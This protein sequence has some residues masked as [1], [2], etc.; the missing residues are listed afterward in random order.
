M[1]ITV[2]FDYHSSIENARV[3]RIDIGI[4]DMYDVSVAWLSSYIYQEKIELSKRKISF[5]IPKIQLNEG[6][7]N[8]NLYSTVDNEVSDWVKNVS[9]INIVFGNYY[10]NGQTLPAEQ[11]PYVT[12]FKIIDK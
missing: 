11:C 8:I 6:V 5:K 12:D 9:S 3:S 1:T 2:Y 7:Y 10:K 4:R